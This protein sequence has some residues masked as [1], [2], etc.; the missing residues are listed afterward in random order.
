MDGGL[1]RRM[2]TGLIIRNAERRHITV[3]Q[4]SRQTGADPG[5]QND[6]IDHFGE[7]FAMK[8]LLLATALIALPVAVFSGV[9]H[10]V[11]G[12]TAAPAQQGAGPSLGDLSKFAAIVS[13]T[14][15]IAATGD[16]V[17]AE[18]RITDLET[19]WDDAEE[20][21]RA[22]A[23]DPAGVETALSDLRATLADPTPFAAVG[24][25]A[26]TLDGIAVTDAAGHPLP[27]EVMLSDLRDALSAG[28]ASDTARPQIADLQSKATERC[29]A[30]DDRRADAFSAQALAL[31]TPTKV[32]R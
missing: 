22:K 25:A 10:F 24:G 5:P 29:N 32:T 6:L 1:W 20:E 31:L 19:A 14:Q 9:E 30:D 27:C 23:P 17:A 18:A 16:L 28:R 3:S 12:A 4:P 26:Q 8:Q 7:D 2:T 13:D 11:I 15:K 21:L